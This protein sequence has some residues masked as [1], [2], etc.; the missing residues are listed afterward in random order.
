MAVEWSDAKPQKK[1]GTKGRPTSGASFATVD[2]KRLT[3][4]R[5]KADKTGEIW[6]A[7][8]NGKRIEAAYRGPNEAKA[9]A[10]KS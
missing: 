3:V 4:Y 7:S 8:V 1:K 9:A 10:E 5:V 6:H 2:G